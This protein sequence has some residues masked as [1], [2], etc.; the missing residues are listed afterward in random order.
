MLHLTLKPSYFDH[1]H[2]VWETGNRTYSLGA[3]T[4]SGKQETTYSVDAITMS[5][6]LETTFSVGAFT[7]SR[8]Q[9]TKRIL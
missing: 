2:C 7:V 1:F 3:F 9:E 8:N 6:K 5:G 4:V